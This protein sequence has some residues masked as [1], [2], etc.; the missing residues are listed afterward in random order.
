MRLQLPST[1]L[2]SAGLFA[3]LFA[4]AAAAQTQAA[5]DV[6]PFI[7]VDAPVFVLAHVRIVDG[8]G[9]PAVEDQSIV[10][11]NGKIQS[12]GPAASV[13]MPQGAQQLD[14]T[15][16]TVI[17][18]LI[19]MHDHLFYVDSAA[20]QRTARAPEPGIVAPEIAFTAPRLYFA[21]GVTTM[22]TT[23]SSEPSSR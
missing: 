18:G 20:Q 4:T 2:C 17:P 10:V 7:T 11:A 5:P 6:A 13:A 1:A 8:T 9:T 21:A 14:K 3:L 15:G 12:I 19:G 23:G 22:R 16:Y